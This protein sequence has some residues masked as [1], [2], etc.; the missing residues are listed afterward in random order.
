MRSAATC[1]PVLPWRHNPCRLERWLSYFPVRLTVHRYL[2]GPGSGGVGNSGGGGSAPRGGGISRLVVAVI[3]GMARKFVAPF[4]AE[5]D[6]STPGWAASSSC[7]L[8]TTGGDVMVK[9]RF[10]RGRS[11]EF[12]RHCATAAVAFSLACY[13][14]EN[15]K[16]TFFL[17]TFRCSARWGSSPEQFLTL[18]S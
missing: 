14:I 15:E 3:T 10:L 5:R 1:P 4:G 8:M 7:R 18:S 9:G 2:T 17:A 12:W 11:G 6:D 13:K 16:L